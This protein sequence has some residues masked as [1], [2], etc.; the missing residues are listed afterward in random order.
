MMM[1]TGVLSL[2]VQV[3]VVGRVV[4]AVGERG[5]L[6]GG[7]F[8]AAA[9]FVVYGMAPNWIVF[10]CASPLGALGGLIGPGAQSLM[11]RRVPG[12]Q[13]GRLQGVNSAFM[14]ICS[15][16]GP[17]IYLGSLSF[18]VQHEPAAP[19]GL[20]ILIAAGFCAAALI[21][22]LVLAK[23]VADAEPSPS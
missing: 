14:G 10:L 9:A 6:L 16:L 17:V 18:A 23:P 20:P 13:Q 19:P 4:K 21:A 1:L 3:F 12:N 15:I 7:L 5:A 22:A 11:S 2:L 8:F